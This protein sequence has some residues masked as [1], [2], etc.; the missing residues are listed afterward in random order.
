VWAEIRKET[1]PMQSMDKGD[2]KKEGVQ[3]KT[4]IIKE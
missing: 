2:V 1:T 3:A 4:N